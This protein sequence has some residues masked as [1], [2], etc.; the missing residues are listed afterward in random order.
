MQRRIAVWFESIS[1]TGMRKGTQAISSAPGASII[2]QVEKGE[3][4]TR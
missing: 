2:W 3:A 4:A 1:G